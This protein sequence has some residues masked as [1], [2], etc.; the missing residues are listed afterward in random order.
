[1][2]FIKQ[3]ACVA[4][5]GTSPATDLAFASFAAASSPEPS[6]SR[7]G[8]A[9]D[10]C[11][12]PQFRAALGEYVKSIGTKDHPYFHKQPGGAAFKGDTVNVTGG[13]IRV[14]IPEAPLQTSYWTYKGLVQHPVDHPGRTVRSDIG[15]SLENGHKRA[16]IFITTED[17]SL[18]MREAT[19]SIQDKLDPSHKVLHS[20]FTGAKFY[21]IAEHSP[22]PSEATFAPDERVTVSVTLRKQNERESLIILSAESDTKRVTAT[23]PRSDR[24]I[25]NRN[26]LELHDVCGATEAKLSKHGQ[27]KH[28]ELALVSLNMLDPND[29]T[30][31]PVVLKLMNELESASAQAARSESEP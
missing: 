31:F 7:V 5:A 15:I 25:C 9:D 30:R 3:L 20:R 4:L 8:G 23:I 19:I 10:L 2:Q 1:M 6:Y 29:Y 22:H 18:R 11:Q 13:S 14:I 12:S 16:S 21:R 17:R 26:S 24:M 27:R 28:D